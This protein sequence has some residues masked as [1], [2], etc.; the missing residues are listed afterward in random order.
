M[1]DER[2]ILVID[3]AMEGCGVAV[4]DA[5]RDT[6]FDAYSDEAHG[7]AQRLVPMVQSVV[8][9]AGI[10]FDALSDIVVCNG[11]GT[12]TGI[13]IGLSSAGALGLAVGIPVYSYTSLQGLAMTAKSRGLDDDFVVLVETRRQDFYVQGFDAAGIAC[14][15]HQS[16]MRE[17]V[18]VGGRILIGN[19]AR[20]FD[21]K[22]VFAHYDVD[23]IDVGVVARM[24]VRGDV[25]FG[26]D[27]VPIYLRAPDVSQPKN[28]PR[29]LSV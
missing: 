28:A 4:F 22:G 14:D 3:T 24:F 19:A 18:D 26:D 29:K 2:K 12:F 17:N 8:E 27:C 6:V 13:R 25:V 1:S 11:P 10:G 16:L 23:K 9:D 5:G 20:R 21:H 15:E 7:Q